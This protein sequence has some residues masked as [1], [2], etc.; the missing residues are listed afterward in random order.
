MK[1]H[2]FTYTLNK[3]GTHDRKEE[4]VEDNSELA[5]AVEAEVSKHPSEIVM[6]LEHKGTIVYVGPLEGAK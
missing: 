6:G 1:V 3:N 5:K 2:K 4:T